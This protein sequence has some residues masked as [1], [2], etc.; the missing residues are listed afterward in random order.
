MWLPN[1]RGVASKSYSSRQAVCL[2]TT[3]LMAC[4]GGEEEGSQLEGIPED[5]CVNKSSR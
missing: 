2:A 1:E 5:L 3:P 4:G